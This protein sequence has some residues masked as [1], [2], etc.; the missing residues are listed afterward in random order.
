VVKLALVKLALV[1][2]ALVPGFGTR[3]R[4]G[5]PG[6]EPEAGEPFEPGFTPVFE[7]P[8]RTY[9]RI[10]SKSSSIFEYFLPKASDTLESMFGFGSFHGYS[11]ECLVDT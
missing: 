3:P 7:D 6:T 2:L 10:G 9:I 4:P 8:F 11:F 5:G 1:K